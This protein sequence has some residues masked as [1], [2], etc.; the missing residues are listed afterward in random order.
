MPQRDY[1]KA[2]RAKPRPK[3]TAPPPKNYPWPLM[4]LAAVLL[5][6]FAWFLYH[7]STRDPVAIPEPEKRAAITPQKELPPKPKAEPYQYIKELENKEIQVKVE[8]LENKGPFEMYCGVYRVEET[9]EQ[10]KAKIAFAGYPSTVRRIEGKNGVFYRVTL[11]PYA[12]K[13]QAESEKNRLNRQKV[14]DC[15]IA[16]I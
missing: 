16:A 6:A 5:L 10:L 15:R 12:S 1:V 7:L 8:E 4:V 3:K 11:G 13:R 9:A 2:G 14:A